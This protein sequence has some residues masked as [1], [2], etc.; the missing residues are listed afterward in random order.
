M[1]WKGRGMFS[2]KIEYGYIIIQELKETNELNTKLGKDILKNIQV[3]YNMGLGILS[4]LSKSELIISTKGKN[5]GYY[6]KNKDITFFE[7]FNSLEIVSKVRR[8]KY[9]NVSYRDKILKINLHF[10]N[11]LKNIKILD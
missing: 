9:N 4:E 3:P 8:N 5:G 11:D 6:L 1:F 10:L 7:L 2:K